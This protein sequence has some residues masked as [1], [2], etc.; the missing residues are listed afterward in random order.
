MRFA[1]DRLARFKGRGGAERTIHI[2]EPSQPRAVIMALHGALAH[3]GD[4]VTPA[5]YFRDHDIALASF[6]MCGHEGKRRADIPDFDIFLDEAELFLQW[7]KKHYPDLPIFIMGH[8]MGALIAT[9]FGLERMRRSD[10]VKGFILSSPYYVNAVKV[11]AILQNISGLLARFFPK[12]KVPLASFTDVLTHDAAIT[13]RH[14][15]DEADNVRA[16]E[17]TVRFGHA[18][19]EA[20]K[21]LAAKMPTWRFPI[22]AVVAGDDKLAD[23]RA[24]EAM[25]KTVDGGLLEYRCEPANYHE[26]FNETNREDI[27]ADILRWMTP[28]IGG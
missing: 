20:Q 9:R 25:L 14:H 2:W 5:L 24:A 3:A 26:N 12:M 18:L 6:D 13:A 17:L 8:S 16:S 15:A 10:E 23:G 19:S 4:Y 28:R 21:G 11:P 27:F 1:E 22:Y 7:I